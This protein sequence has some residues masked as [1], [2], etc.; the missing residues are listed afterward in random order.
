MATVWRMHETATDDEESVLERAAGAGFELVARQTDTGQ[1][2]WE[3]HNAAGPRP[4][5]VSERLAH[6]WMTEWLARDE[7]R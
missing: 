3:W 2:V 6:S 7:H 4:Q 5:F 1:V